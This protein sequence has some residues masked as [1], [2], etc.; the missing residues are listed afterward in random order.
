MAFLCT[1]L[2]T[3]YNKGFFPH[4]LFPK[5]IIITVQNIHTFPKP[6]NKN[7][8]VCWSYGCFN[9]WHLKVPASTCNWQRQV[10]SL[11]PLSIM[12]Q[13][14]KQGVIEKYNLSCKLQNGNFKSLEYQRLQGVLIYS[15]KKKCCTCTLSYN[16]FNV[17]TFNYMF[18]LMKLYCY[19]FICFMLIPQEKTW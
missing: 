17:F 3:F 19:A 1:V 9:P 16:T 7:P 2:K 4:N 13:S 12:T 18:Y 11:L 8:P 14:L 15:A 5:F 6:C 10:L